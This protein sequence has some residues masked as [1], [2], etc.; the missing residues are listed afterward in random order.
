MMAD[1]F[2][3]EINRKRNRTDDLVSIVPSTENDGA[4]VI[5][6]GGHFGQYLDQDADK[7]K[8]EVDLKTLLTNQLWATMMNHLLI[9]Y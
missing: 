9:L 7:A 6:S 4:G 1:F 2:G 8:N 3:F 5:N